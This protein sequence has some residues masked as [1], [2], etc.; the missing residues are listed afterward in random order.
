MHVFFQPD[1]DTAAIQLNEDESKHCVR[2]LRLKKGD[3]VHLADGKG[4]HALA[5]IGDDN[6][7]RCVLGITRKENNSKNRTYY[8]HI[9]IAPTKNFERTEWFIEKAVEAGI[10]EITF[11]ETQNS[12]RNKVNMERCEKIAVSAMKQSKQWWLPAINPIVKLSDAVAS[13]ENGLK[14]MAWCET[15]EEQLLNDALKN[16]AQQTIT[17]LI[18]PEG[19]FTAQEVELAKRAG[20]QPVSLGKNI[21]RTETAALYACMAVKAIL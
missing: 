9:I 1:L 11:I 18:G 7:K 19:D 17:V 20:F 13:V 8:L 15:N 16:D 21:L 14:L 5:Q 3:E 6:P 2:V 4:T 12:E 10:D